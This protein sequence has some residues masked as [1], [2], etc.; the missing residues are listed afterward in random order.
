MQ[1][2]IWTWLNPKREGLDYIM[3]WGF[4]LSSAELVAVPQAQY[5][6]VPPRVCMCMFADKTLLAMCP[7]SLRSWAC[8]TP[9]VDAVQITQKKCSGLW[10]GLGLGLGVL[11][12]RTSSTYSRDSRSRVINRDNLSC[13][14]RLLFFIVCCVFRQK[15][16]SLIILYFLFS[17]A[18]WQL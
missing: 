6:L 10:L 9:I 15:I 7:C 8:D 2:V 1:Q 13:F 14:Q 18:P 12:A 5:P 17:V 4:S 3:V 11:F 16:N